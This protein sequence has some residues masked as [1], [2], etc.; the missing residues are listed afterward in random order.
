MLTFL[1]EQFG[2]YHPT[3]D[4]FLLVGAVRRSGHHAVIDW[5]CSHYETS[6]FFNHLKPPYRKVRKRE[7]N[8]H[9]ELL[10]MNLERCSASQFEEWC[11]SKAVQAIIRDSKAATIRRVTVVR[12]PF[13]CLASQLKHPHSRKKVGPDLIDRLKS[14]MRLALDPPTGIQPILFNQFVA[15][16]PYRRRISEWLGRPYT[17]A[18]LQTVSKYGSDSS[19]DQRAF[20]GK[21]T[22]MNVFER[23]KEFLDDPV[24]RELTEDD[25]LH[26][27]NRELFDFDIR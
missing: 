6:H 19:F 7:Y 11:D 22:Q 24:F 1:R 23:W 17:D 13:N 15:S 4:E 21:A 9:Y 20:D 27:L 16:E 8:Q 12:D 26:A 3:A 18:T 10:A 14:H 5:L 2:T 25:E